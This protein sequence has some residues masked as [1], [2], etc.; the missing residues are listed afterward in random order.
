[1]IYLSYEHGTC[2]NCAN[3]ICVNNLLN[4]SWLSDLFELKFIARFR[5]QSLHFI[6]PLS[7]FRTFTLDNHVVQNYTC[8]HDISD[9]V[10]I[11]QPWRILHYR[12]STL[13]HTKCPLH[14]LARCLLTA[15]KIDLLIFWWACDRLHKDGLVWVYPIRQ[16]VAHIVLV[17]VGDETDG[18]TNAHALLVEKGQW[19]EGVDVVIWPSYSKIRM[20]NP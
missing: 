8:V 12:P 20:S 15:R 4:R 5:C 1:M 19:L 11:P 3:R 9:S 17:A 6:G 7:Q 14:I 16:I 10:N 2:D 18:R 13:E